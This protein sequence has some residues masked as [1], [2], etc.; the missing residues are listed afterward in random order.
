MQPV[1]LKNAKILL[2]GDAPGRAD[3]AAGRPFTSHAGS[4]LDYILAD[5]GLSR[6]DVS[7][8]NVFD[9]P[10]PEGG[11][12]AWALPRK[13]VKGLLNKELP[14]ENV[15]CKKG[16]VSPHIMQP[17]LLRLALEIAAAKPNVIGAL[18]NVALAALC[19]VTGI[20]KFRGALNQTEG[21]IKVIPSYHPLAILKQYEIR[22]AVIA[23]FM[24]M[25]LHSGYPEARTKNRKLYIEPTLSDLALWEK[26]LSLAKEISLDIETK[27]KQITC[28][29]FAPSSTES[30]V[31]PFWHGTE[32]YWSQEEEVEAYK[33]VRRI[34]ANSAIKICQNGLYDVQYLAHYNIPVL[35]FT[36]DTMLLHHALYP[37]LPKG[38]DYLGSI[39]CDEAAWKRWRIRGGDSLKK[40]E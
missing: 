29:G 14:W 27:I 26:E 8:T 30:Y 19:A 24:K 18:G 21:G 28:I 4:E 37:A 20:K 39:Y 32:N 7:L 33:F 3:A 1:I 17:A 9:I 13:D 11:I 16:V 10:Y 40:E 15:P 2:I 35:N 31:L 34:C 5:S 36:E 22:P 12:D 38:L 23:D 6:A 25:K